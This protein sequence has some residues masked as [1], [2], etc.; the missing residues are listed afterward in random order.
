MPHALPPLPYPYGG[1]HLNH[2]LFWEST[3]VDERIFA[4]L[5][6]GARGLVLKDTD[7]A[8]LVRAIELLARGDAVLSPSLT[9]RLTAELASVP[10]PQ[11]PS[12]ELLDELTPREREVVALVALAPPQR[13]STPC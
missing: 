12:S 8:E 13:R 4:T 9:R 3:G 1:G 7:P 11:L 2:S 10:D 6:P 5:R